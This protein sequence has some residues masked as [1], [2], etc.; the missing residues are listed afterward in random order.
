MPNLSL[1]GDEVD[2][3]VGY[4]ENENQRLVG[5]KTNDA[6]NETNQH[7]YHMHAH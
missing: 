4:L 5:K 1:T 6:K 2:Q 3:V 7:Q